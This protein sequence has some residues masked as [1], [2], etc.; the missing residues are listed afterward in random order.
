[1]KRFIKTKFFLTLQ[2]ASQK[3]VNKD[4]EALKSRY[5]EFAIFLFSES[6]VFTD[7]AAYHNTLV[8][9]RIELA[10]LT[11]GLGKKY[12]NLSKKSHWTY[13]YTDRMDRKTAIN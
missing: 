7:K 13:R 10:N 3:G 5:D 1:M 9:T 6:T 2:E 11:R 8:Y 4:A 12:D